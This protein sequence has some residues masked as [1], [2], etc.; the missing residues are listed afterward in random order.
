MKV[1][2][3]GMNHLCMSFFFQIVFVF[4]FSRIRIDSFELMVYD[5]NNIFYYDSVFRP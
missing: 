2:L 5:R 4:P 3:L 1:K